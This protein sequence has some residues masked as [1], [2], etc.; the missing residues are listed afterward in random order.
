[1]AKANN[2]RF[3]PYVF[4]I[5]DSIGEKKIKMTKLT[6]GFKCKSY[7]NSHW[8]KD[9]TVTVLNVSNFKNSQWKKDQQKEK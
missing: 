2:E 6:N 7:E 3:L 4:H 5:F 9:L 8:K 1:M